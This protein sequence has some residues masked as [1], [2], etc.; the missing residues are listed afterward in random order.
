M[1]TNVVK[2]EELAEFRKRA[3]EAVVSLRREGEEAFYYHGPR[4]SMVTVGVFGPKDLDVTKPGRESFAL[5]EARRK[6]PFNLV[7]GAQLL[8]KTKT[9]QSQSAQPSF[10]LQIPD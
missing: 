3:E 5:R 2:P 1:N 10:V 8:V 9:Q 7:N 6:F 4:G